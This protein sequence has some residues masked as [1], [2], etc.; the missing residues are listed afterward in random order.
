MAMTLWKKREMEEVRVGS[1]ARGV[2]HG[3]GR[4]SETSVRMQLLQA[5]ELWQMNRKKEAQQLFVLAAK[6][7]PTSA[8]AAVF[9]RLLLRKARDIGVVDEFLLKPPSARTAGAMSALESVTSTHD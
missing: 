1:F 6:K 2:R 7:E 8:A 5:L 9:C 3:A 4:R